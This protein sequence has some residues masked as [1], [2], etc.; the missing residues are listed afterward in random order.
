MAV[1]PAEITGLLGAW[2]GSDREALNRLM[3]VVY[4]E[5]RRAARN[6]IRHAFRGAGA[7]TTVV[8]P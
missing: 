7:T 3:S 2:E 6:Y 1:V 5:L 4:E 8:P